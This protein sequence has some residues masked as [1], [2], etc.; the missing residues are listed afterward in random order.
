M[1][2]KVARALVTASPE[3][4]AQTSIN[5]RITNVAGIDR[6]ISDRCAERNAYIDSL[7]RLRDAGVDVSEEL[8]KVYADLKHDY[9]II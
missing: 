4:I 5:Y 1:I 6:S 3:F 9:R 7:V 8:E 2:L